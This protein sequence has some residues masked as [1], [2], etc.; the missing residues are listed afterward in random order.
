MS[1]G[2]VITACPPDSAAGPS[3]PAPTCHCW[4]MP[5]APGFV[6]PLCLHSFPPGPTLLLGSLGLWAAHGWC[7]ADQAPGKPCWARRLSLRQA[8]QSTSVHPSRERETA[9]ARAEADLLLGFH[10]DAGP[11][12]GRRC[13]S[14]HVPYQTG[15]SILRALSR[16]T[17]FASGLQ[18]CPVLGAGQSWEGLL[19]AHMEARWWRVLGTPLSLPHSPSEPPQPSIQCP[20]SSCSGVRGLPGRA[21]L[22]CCSCTVRRHWGRRPPAAARS[23]HSL[24]RRGLS[25]LMCP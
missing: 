14:A 16:P 11:A 22:L 15:A 20:G 18:P 23:S 9:L 17:Y 10:G 6:H 1:R 8:L 24:R 21:G 12:R 5:P 4:L 13:V 7:A 19:D 25:P 3:V 2:Q